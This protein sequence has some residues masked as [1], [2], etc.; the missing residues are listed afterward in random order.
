MAIE[1]IKKGALPKGKEFMGLKTN[2]TTGVLTA[3][4]PADVATAYNNGYFVVGA[5]GVARRTVAGITQELRLKNPF[6][7]VETGQVV[8]ASGKPIVGDYDL[9]AVVPLKSP[10]RNIVGVPKDP[11]KGDWMG[12]DVQR[13]AS[14]VNKRLDQRRVLHGAQDQFP[15]RELGGLTDDLAYAVYPDGSICILNGRAAQAAF[16]KQYGRQTILGKY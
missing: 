4:K 16:F 13:Y 1:L 11:A 9:L 14:A 2:P 7:K 12:P 8:S 15:N 5:D 6:W 10:G 3:T